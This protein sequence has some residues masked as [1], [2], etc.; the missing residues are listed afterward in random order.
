MAMG[1]KCHFSTLR[2]SENN[3]AVRRY[4]PFLETL[5]FMPQSAC[6]SP[7]HSSADAKC[8]AAVDVEFR[9]ASGALTPNLPINCGNRIG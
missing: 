4:D 8:A 7:T 2:Q 5:T 9:L 1:K 3:C 6:F